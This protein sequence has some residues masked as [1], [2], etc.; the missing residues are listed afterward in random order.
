M[1]PL[2]TVVRVSVVV[3]LLAVISLWATPAH[4]IGPFSISLQFPGS[5]CSTEPCPFGG[6]NGNSYVWGPETAATF[7]GISEEL[8]FTHFTDI[9]TVD[10]MQMAAAKQVIPTAVLTVNL[11]GNAETTI[12]MNN[13]RVKSV[14]EATDIFSN[15]GG[16][17]VEIVTFAFS[18]V[19]YTFQPLTPTG[20][21][22]GPPVSY[23][24]TFK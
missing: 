5:T 17:P 15:N 13:A 3:A 12:Q 6:Y 21:K 1:K 10:L 23:F 14:R 7:K 22:A 20:Q 16:I 19:D 2:G 18:S 9:T 4:A 8:S 24:V 11:N